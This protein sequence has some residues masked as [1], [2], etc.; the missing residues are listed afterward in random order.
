MTARDKSKCPTCG[1]IALISP[2]GY[3]SRRRGDRH[4]LLPRKKAM[5]LVRRGL[6]ELRGTNKVGMNAKP[7]A[8]KESRATRIC[9]LGPSKS[10]VACLDDWH[11]LSA[12]RCPLSCDLRGSRIDHWHEDGPGRVVCSGICFNHR[13]DPDN[14]YDDADGHTTDHYHLRSDIKRKHGPS[15][16]RARS[17]RHIARQSRERR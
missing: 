17:E 6:A 7:M 10:W 9:N 16:S 1:D 15:N 4:V 14:K 12:V 5:R 2:S 13:Y 8:L 3:L 11:V